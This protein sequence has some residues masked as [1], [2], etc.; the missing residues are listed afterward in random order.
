[1]TRSQQK[2]FTLIE[3][4]IVVAIVGILAAVA[5][6]AY[7]NYMR[8]SKYTEVVVASSPLK[9]AVELCAQDLSTVTGCNTNTQGIPTLVG[10]KYVAGGAVSN[11]IISITATSVEGLSGETYILQPNYQAGAPL[12][13]TQAGSCVAAGL[14]K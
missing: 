9:L 2:G 7:Q 11:G 14:C 10:S 1:M 12:Q 3:L 8:R 6:P 4:M 13:F 5:M